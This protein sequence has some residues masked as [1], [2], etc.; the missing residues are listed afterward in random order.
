MG[1]SI[2]IRLLAFD[3][4]NKLNSNIIVAKL[5]GEPGSYSYKS[6][7]HFKTSETFFS[8][9]TRTYSCDE[10]T[11]KKLSRIISDTLRVR[12]IIGM[13]GNVILERV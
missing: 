12:H 1:E 4:F 3:K 13:N 7:S 5:G 6:E 10:L 11:L 8:L 9:E 2:E